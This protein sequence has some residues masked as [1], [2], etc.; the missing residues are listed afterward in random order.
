MT[1]YASPILHEG[2]TMSW[3][4]EFYNERAHG[5]DTHCTLGSLTVRSGWTESGLSLQ[6]PSLTP[7]LPT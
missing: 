4:M 5:T 1:R 6:P 3:L 2:S 7:G